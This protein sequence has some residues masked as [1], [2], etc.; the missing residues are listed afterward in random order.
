MDGIPLD[1]G[2][3]VTADPGSSSGGSSANLVPLQTG[4]DFTWYPAAAALGPT[5]L[6]AVASAPVAELTLYNGLAKPVSALVHAEGQSDVNIVVDSGGV[7]SFE[8][9]P[10]TVYRLDADAGLRAAVTYSGEGES[11]ASS[12]RP[13]SRLG[14]TILVYPR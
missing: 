10:N 6:V 4:G 3:G 14:S 13:P 7:V 12:V 2:E 5:T 1:G 11:S 9:A 8:I